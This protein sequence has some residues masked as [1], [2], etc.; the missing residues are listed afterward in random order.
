MSV[1]VDS[2]S[3]KF[4]EYEK[5]SFEDEK[6]R[7]DNFAIP[8]QHEPS[9]IGYVIV[10]AGR[11]AHINEARE[12]GERTKRYL[13]KTRKIDKKRVITIDGGHREQL[14]TELYLQGR[15]LPRPPVSPTVKRSEVQIVNP[16]STKNNR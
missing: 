15:G 4:D 14:T 11:H 1:V 8:L 7:L 6:A 5:L 3:P 9:F 13:V 2:F 16:K 12:V 10:Y